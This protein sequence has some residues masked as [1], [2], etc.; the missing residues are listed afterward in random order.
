MPYGSNSGLSAYLS[1][2]GRTLPVGANPDVV[3]WWGSRYVD[4]FEQDYRGSALQTDTSFPRNLWPTVPV[5]VEYAAYESGFA[6]ANG[7]EIFGGGGTAG[8]QVVREKLDVL[9]VQYAAPQEGLGYWDANRYILPAAYALLL[10][11][12]N[13]KGGFFPSALVVP[14]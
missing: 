13:R 5:N 8:G 6:W 1:A 14:Q 7:V 10:P 4:Q 2:S 11:F 3:R 12:M 9:E